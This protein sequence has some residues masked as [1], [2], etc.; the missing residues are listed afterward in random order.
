MRNMRDVNVSTLTGATR[1]MLKRIGYRKKKVF[2]VSTDEER[3]YGTYW[4]GGSRAMYS[5]W[6]P[7]TGRVLRLNLSTSPPQFGGPMQHE[8]EKLSPTRYLVRDGILCGKPA[9]A[10]IYGPDA[11][12]LSSEV[13][14]CD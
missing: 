11:L 1:D 3:P 5:E 2:L 9:H 13:D 4:D 14:Q 10:F 7:Q 8:V 12:H 6:N